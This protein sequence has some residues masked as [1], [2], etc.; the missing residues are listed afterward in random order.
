MQIA[1]NTYPVSGWSSL[2]GL[3]LVHCKLM[4]HSARITNPAYLIIVG[5]QALVLVELQH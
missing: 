5:N 3:A 1:K 4:Q 2:Q